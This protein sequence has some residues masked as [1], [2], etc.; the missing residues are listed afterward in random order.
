MVT[1]RNAYRLLAGAMLLA[2]CA[3]RHP[4]LTNVRY[5]D[6]RRNVLDFFPAP[7]SDQPTPVLICFHGGGF[8]MGSKMKCRCQRITGQ[9][10]A[11]GISVV[12]ANYRYIRGK[13]GA[14]FPAPM[15]DGARAVQFVRSKAE[16]WQID[17]DRIALVGDS[18]GGNMALW[19][20]LH[21]DLADLG[22]QDPVC[23]LSSRVT[24][25][26][27]V[28]A[29]TTNDPR[30]ILENIGGRRG[31]Y[32]PILKFYGI[33]SW[34][35]FDRP[36]IVALVKEA[37]PVS[38]ASQDDPPVLLRYRRRLG[39]TPLAKYAWAPR[40]VHHPLFGEYLKSELE[41]L[42]VECLFFHKDCPA[43]PDSEIKFLIR[44]FGMLG[45]APTPQRRTPP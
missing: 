40:V 45:D 3:Y 21:D 6:R 24:C 18:A 15:R 7:G 20:A 44:H 41:P 4:E 30:W 33:E 11:N 42:G 1:N 9:C 39:G 37:S 22:S 12:S 23:R 2:G 14:P 25:A 32:P 17:P 35:D 10:L 16:E 43:E 28:E 13:H 19:I 38:H 8:I 27:G 26:I 29:Q 36:E 31:V 34:D 5:G